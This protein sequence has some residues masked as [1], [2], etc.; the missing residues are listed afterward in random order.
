VTHTRV[1]GGARPQKMLEISLGKKKSLKVGA[2]ARRQKKKGGASGR[3]PT[4]CKVE[5]EPKKKGSGC[6]QENA[7]HR[8]GKIKGLKKAKGS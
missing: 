6:V 5:K 2:H 1:A 4:I 7:P 8:L 3:G